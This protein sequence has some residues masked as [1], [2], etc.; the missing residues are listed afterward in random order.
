MVYSI[1]KNSYFIYQTSGII[2]IEDLISES[3]EIWFTF[4][5]QGKILDLDN[6][7]GLYRSLW[8]QLN[9]R[10]FPIAYVFF[11]RW[12]ISNKDLINFCIKYILYRKDNNDFSYL[13]FQQ[14]YPQISEEIYCFFWVIY[15]SFEQLNILD[16]E[17][18]VNI[19]KLEMFLPSL[20]YN[21]LNVEFNSKDRT[22]S[23]CL[24]ESVD[25]YDEVEKAILRE[26]V[27]N[28]FNGSSDLKLRKKQILASSVGFYDDKEKSLKKMS[29]QMDI[30]GE[31]I[32]VLKHEATRYYR[33]VKKQDGK[34]LRSIYENYDY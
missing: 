25:E 31:R 15:N 21:Y 14:L 23:I 33:N 32:P 4:C 29:D 17:K 13:G 26:Q 7:Y 18:K 11:K 24:L 27:Q 9:T 10:S 12:N 19:R 16:A 34:E 5:I 8:L 20:F 28:I 2:G 3:C 22:S 6:S 1:L 30:S